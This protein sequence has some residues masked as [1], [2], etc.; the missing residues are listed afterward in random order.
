[1]IPVGGWEGPSPHA[2]EGGPSL[3]EACSTG[4]AAGTC[5]KCADGEL[6]TEERNKVSVWL[7]AGD[8]GPCVL[9][10]KGLGGSPLT[11]RSV[12]N[13]LGRP[14][15]YLV[16]NLNLGKMFLENVTRN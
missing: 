13:I 14:S 8:S 5:A 9:R 4:E 15:R 6:H 1:M 11:A 12:S 3:E 2:S 16:S 7:C 10:I